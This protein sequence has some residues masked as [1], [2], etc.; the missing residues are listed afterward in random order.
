[1]G[2]NIEE[3]LVIAVT[4]SA[5]FDMTESN[6]IFEGLGEDEY[7][8][9]QK[10]HIDQPLDKGVAFPFIKRLLALNKAFPEN[11]IE[12]VLLS[13]NSIETGLRAFR[14]IQYYG[15]DIS[16]ACFTKGQRNYHYLPAFNSSLFLSSNPDDVKEALEAGYAAGLIL[17]TKIEDSEDDTEL[18]L[19]FDFDGVIADDSSEKVYQE[20]KNNNNG[21]GLP[22]Y[23]AHERSYREHPLGVGP[24]GKLLQQISEFQKR[25][26]QQR[27]KDSSYKKMLKTFIVTA[28]NAPAHE[29]VVSTLL[30]LKIE[31]DEV[32][33][34]GGIDKSRVLNILKPHIF[35]DD[36]KIHLE[37]LDGIPAIHIPFGVAN[38]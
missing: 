22:T 15:L 21:N 35:F 16:R 38:Q 14:S 2:Y 3:K 1:M 32:F 7:R 30:D 20:A 8:K 10:K 27:E 6:K 9:Y 4:S 19:A 25:E 31:V 37:H 34:M 33:F 18:R 28:R 13:K 17:N 23:L 29:R 36:Q 5:L 12:V 11:P 24:I 26:Q